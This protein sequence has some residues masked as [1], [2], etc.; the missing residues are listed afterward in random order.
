MKRSI[1]K[2]L[3]LTSIITLGITTLTSIPLIINYINGT[4]AQFTLIVDFHVWFGAIF[5]IS[6]LSRIILNRK[7]VMNMIK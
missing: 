3:L 6:T 7:I 5:I 1:N 4:D 2:I